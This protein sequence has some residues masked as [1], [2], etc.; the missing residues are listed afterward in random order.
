MITR[1]ALALVGIFAAV[2]LL[3]SGHI[4]WAAIAFLFCLYLTL[5]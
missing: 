1:M 4:F 3:F 5:A 2:G